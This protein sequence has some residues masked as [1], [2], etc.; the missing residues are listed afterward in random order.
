[1]NN[2]TP[3]QLLANIVLSFH[4][5]VVLFIIFGLIFIVVGNL[6]GWRWVNGLWFRIAHLSAIAVVA[7]QA[8]IGVICPLTSLEMW[9]RRKAHGTTYTGSFIEHWLKYILYYQAPAWV[10]TLIY[11]LFGLLVATTWWYFP[12]RSRRHARKTDD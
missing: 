4:V 7:V 10:F 1:M 11:T 3:Y 6:S 8:W 9:L 2:L 5:A 12:P